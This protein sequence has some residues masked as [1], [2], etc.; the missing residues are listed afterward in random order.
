[1]AKGSTGEDANQVLD[2][3]VT[4]ETT[5]NLQG[6]GNQY[7]DGGKRTMIKM[8]IPV[9]TEASI[10]AEVRA[11]HAHDKIKEAEEAKII[12]EELAL[13]KAEEEEAAKVKKKK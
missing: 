3:T 2:I 1:M 10:R 13:I 12:E 9:R 5:I 11:K 7:Q 6:K 4:E 8:G